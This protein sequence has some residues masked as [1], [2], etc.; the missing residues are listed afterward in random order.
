MSETYSPTSPRYT[1]SSPTWVYPSSPMYSPTSPAY[2][3]GTPPYSPYSSL[4]N[5]QEKTIV[6]LKA[7]LYMKEKEL[8]RKEEEVGRKDR[9]IVALRKDLESEDTLLG[10]CVRCGDA[11]ILP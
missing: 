6:Q 1:P 11:K 8:L 5:E 4:E 3:G 10:R 7:L 2:N 9:Q